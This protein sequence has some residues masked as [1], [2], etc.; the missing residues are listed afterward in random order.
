[1]IVRPEIELSSSFPDDSLSDE[2][3]FIAWPGRNIAEAIKA[4]LERLDYRV[5]EPIHAHENGGELDIWRGR[6][7]LWL[8]IS[9]LDAEVNY[10][11]AEN[12]TFV[13]WSDVE[14]FRRFLADLQDVL[15]ADGRFSRIRRFPKG[16]IAERATPAA[17]PF[18]D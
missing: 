14:L 3:D 6:K 8:Q 11:M 2:I 16:G 4:A 7:R 17:G 15:E 12:I 9:V 13:L 18:G 1:M 5:S 10:L